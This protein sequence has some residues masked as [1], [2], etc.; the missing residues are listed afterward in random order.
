MGVQLI[1]AGFFSDNTQVHYSHPVADVL[2]H[3]KI[4]GDEQVCQLQFF[5]QVF[6]QVDHLRLN[7][8]I[9]GGI[10]LITDDQIGI[11]GVRASHA[12][13]LALPSGKFMRVPL[14]ERSV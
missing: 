6:Q 2:D 13:T 1:T 5:L 11:Q 10:G 9:Q 7:R 3:G 8:N 14:D 4:M 12:D